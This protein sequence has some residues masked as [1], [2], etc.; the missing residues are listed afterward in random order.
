LDAA[1]GF[2]EEPEEVLV[3]LAVLEDAPVAEEAA[4]DFSFQLIFLVVV[5]FLVAIVFK[6][7]ARIIVVQLW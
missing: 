6:L 1:D 3:L 4:L 2:E 5:V 7:L